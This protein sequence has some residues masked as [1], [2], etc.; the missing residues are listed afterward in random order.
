MLGRVENY[1]SS[2]WTYKINKC[3][4]RMI[5]HWSMSLDFHSWRLEYMFH[6]ILLVEDGKVDN[7]I[8]LPLLFMMVW[9]RNQNWE[10][11]LLL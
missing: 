7:K 2:G 6:S 10:R 4:G 3:W 9:D 8:G 11:G 5:F 1:Y